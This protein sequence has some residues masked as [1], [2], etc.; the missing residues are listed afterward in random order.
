MNAKAAQERRRAIAPWRLTVTHARD[1]LVVARI[2]P[3]CLAI[4]RKKPIMDLFLVQ[5][6][7]LAAA[8]ASDPGNIAF[9]CV[10]ES[11]AE[12]PDQAVRDASADMIASFGKDLAACA[13]VIEG[14]G[15]RAAI[16]RTVLASMQFVARSA[17]PTRFFERVPIAA[18]WL[19]DVVAPGSES[20]LGDQ[21][22]LAR[23]RL[24]AASL[25]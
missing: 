9:L 13:C 20:P 23:K 3:V 18:A 14:T 22:E 12:P 19:T 21:V 10:V 1:G 25:T 17:T 7:D 8:V 16:T 15:F 2:G 6:F 11:G 5:R 4:W 24:D